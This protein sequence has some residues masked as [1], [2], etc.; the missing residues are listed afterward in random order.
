VSQLSEE[1]VLRGRGQVK[2]ARDKFRPVPGTH[3]GGAYP[4]DV[5]QA[6]HTVLDIIVV[7]ERHRKPIGRPSLTLLVCLYSR[8]ITGYYLSL[9]PPSET[10]IG[11]AMAQSILPKEDW[12]S[13][14]DVQGEWPVWGFPRMLQVDN[15]ADFRSNSLQLATQGN[16]ITLEFCPVRLPNYKGAVER[17]Y[18]TINAEMHDLPGT[19]FSNTQERSEYD[20]N[21]E[22]ALTLAELERWLLNWICNVYHCTP[23]RTLVTSPLSRWIIGVHGDEEEAGI[24][25]PAL[26]INRQTVT[27][28]FMPFKR[29]T[30]QHTGV[31]LFGLQY[32]AAVLKSWIARQNPTTESKLFIF[33][34]D[35]RDISRIWFYDPVIKDYFE[36]PL[37]DQRQPAISLFELKRAKTLLKARGRKL[38]DASEEVLFA[39]VGEGRQLVDDARESSTVAR[40]DA[41][42]SVAHKRKMNPADPLQKARPTPPP[43]VASTG[44]LLEDEVKTFGG[45]A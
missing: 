21:K 12:L 3:P 44:S 32:D 36:V 43:P 25:L 27:L 34:Y 4:L 37:A 17:L 41:Q 8:M 19:T 45:V 18:R 16:G 9:D 10:S 23:H 33:K 22:A 29:R 20:A 1:E 26:P 15:G 24:G 11:L 35:P 6:D 14:H 31:E 2:K 42:R 7:D 28:D 38:K 39:A 40:R 30:V 5:V 13:A